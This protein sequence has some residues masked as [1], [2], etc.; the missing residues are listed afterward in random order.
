[1]SPVE[2]GLGLEVR[3][4]LTSGDNE[5]ALKKSGLMSFES[6][7]RVVEVAVEVEGVE[8]DKFCV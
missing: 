4:G 3:S 2:F 8:N 1:M 6:G 7:V 5:S